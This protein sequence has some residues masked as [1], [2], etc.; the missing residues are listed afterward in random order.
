MEQG[1]VRASIG[2][3]NTVEEIDALIGAVREIVE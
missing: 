3:F 1:L 2:F